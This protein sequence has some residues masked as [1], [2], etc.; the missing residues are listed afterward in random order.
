MYS[1]I[2]TG[3]FSDIGLTTKN[4]TTAATAIPPIIHNQSNFKSGY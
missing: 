3:S 1:V 2:S 4:I